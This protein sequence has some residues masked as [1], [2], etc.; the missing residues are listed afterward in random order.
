LVVE[1]RHGFALVGNRN[2]VDEARVDLPSHRLDGGA[3]GPPPI[4]GVLLEAMEAH[5]SDGE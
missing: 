2:P 3:C 1:E 4:R 5:L